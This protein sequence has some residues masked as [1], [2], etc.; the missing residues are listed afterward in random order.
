MSIASLLTIS[1]IL[2]I[3]PIIYLIYSAGS[4][5]NWLAL[6]IFIVAAV[7]DYFDG[8]LARKTESE[9][10]FGALLD[11]LADKLLV[12]ITLISL[13]HI[14]NSVYFIVPVIVIVFREITIAT[15]RQL[16]DVQ[17]SGPVRVT[18]F[19]KIKTTIQMIAIALNIISPEM[20]NLF[21]IVAISSLWLASL[22]SLAS[23]FSY[24]RSWIEQGL[25]LKK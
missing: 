16:I 20:D 21:N 23:L 8:L 14:N 2:L 1:R 17:K 10:S 18:F 12:C 11:L 9:S 24:L 7:T 19:G 15:I 25:F 5:Q 13:I 22:I 4:L 6:I 3:L